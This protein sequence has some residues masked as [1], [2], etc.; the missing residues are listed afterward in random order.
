[1]RG[2]A[3]GDVCSG[4]PDAQLLTAGALGAWDPDDDDVAAVDVA[5]TDELLAVA[6]VVAHMDVLVAAPAG[7]I[8]AVFAAR[9]PTPAT[10]GSSAHPRRRG[11]AVLV[12]S[13]SG[14]EVAVD[15]IRKERGLGGRDAWG[16]RGSVPA[17]A[18]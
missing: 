12:V 17:G 13:G 7:P 9:A 8:G 10:G 11:S 16:R 4:L 3:V 6:A 14:S 1:M 15:V 5:D 18:S 2:E